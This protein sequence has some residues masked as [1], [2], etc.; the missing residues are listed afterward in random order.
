MQFYYGDSNLL[1]ML[2]EAQ[3]WK[4]QE[5][6]HT[7]VVQNTT[8]NLEKEYVNSLNEFELAFIAMEGCAIR[9]IETVIRSK[10]N[11]NQN[12]KNE[13]YAFIKECIA[14]SQ[15]FIKLLDYM[16]KNS[17]AVKD[18]QFSQVVINHIRRESEYF[19]GIAETIMARYPTDI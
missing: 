17:D 12:L 15:Q 7:A 6:E 5:K 19:I 3:F 10:D 2:D 14:Q 1:R 13:I 18:N 11:I 8:P 16:L 9:L 4:L